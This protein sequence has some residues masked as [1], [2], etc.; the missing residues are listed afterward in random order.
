MDIPTGSEE[1]AVYSRIESG[2]S[3]FDGTEDEAYKSSEMPEKPKQGEEMDNSGESLELSVSPA[4]HLGNTE[5]IVRED[6]QIVTK[7]TQKQNDDE[8][9]DMDYDDFYRPGRYPHT[10]T[11]GHSESSTQWGTNS[12]ETAAWTTADE[13]IVSGENQGIVT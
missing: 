13:M 8:S 12:S 2:V 5:D 4:S 7:D 9:Q 1:E 10:P 6:I 11:K 3:P